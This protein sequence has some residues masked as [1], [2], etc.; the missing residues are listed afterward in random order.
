MRQYTWPSLVQVMVCRLYST[1]Q[2]LN[3]FWYIVNW[4]DMNQ[5]L[6]QF[7]SNNNNKNVAFE[8]ICEIATIL[9]KLNTVNSEE[10]YWVQFSCFVL[11]QRFTQHVKTGNTTFVII[12]EDHRPP[13]EVRYIYLGKKITSS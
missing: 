5:M 3:Q 1:K 2:Y 12:N 9:L 8:N 11:W 4:T 7:E 6:L 10:N 13:T